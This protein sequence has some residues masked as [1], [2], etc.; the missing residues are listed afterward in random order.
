MTM[1]GTYFP[2]F[3]DIR[4]TPVL[5]VGAGKVAERKIDALLA[6]GAAVTVVATRF[7]DP[8]RRRMERGEV[9]G[10][11]SPFLPEHLGGMAMAFAAASDPA[12]NR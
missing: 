9:R 2:I 12:A 7:S 6:H 5:V 10:I 11:R 3:C 4:G 1:S 8:V